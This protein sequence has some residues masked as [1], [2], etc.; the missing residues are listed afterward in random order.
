HRLATHD[1]RI[2]ND[3][4]GVWQ[5]VGQVSDETNPADCFERIFF[6]QLFADENRIDLRA[7]LEEL[8]HR[9]KDAT[10]RRHVEI[11]GAELFDCL[12]DQT[13]IEQNRAENGSFCFG[14]VWEGPFEGLFANR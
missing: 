11:F 12:A 2:V 3:V 5:A 1:L 9:D 7:T 14:T 8:D 4:S 13:V 10:M 6:L